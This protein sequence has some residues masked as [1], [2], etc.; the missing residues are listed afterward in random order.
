ML[1]EHGADHVIDY[2]Q[3][4]FT[5]NGR[6][7]DVIID[8]VGKS[9]FSRSVKSLNPKGRYVL[10]NPTA[11]TMLRGL[12]TSLIS[13]KKVI[14]QFAGYHKEAFE[15][16]KSQIEAGKLKPIIDKRF[17]L[18]RVAEAHR[19]VE[20]GLKAGHVVILVEH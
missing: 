16:I 2:A 15:F 10:G 11:T 3:G 4:D 7:Y 19:Y 18:E 14:S 1:R 12:L 9:S 13:D 20:A 6:T 5:R 8:V 17:S